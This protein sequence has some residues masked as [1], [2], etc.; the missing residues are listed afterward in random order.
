MSNLQARLAAF[1]PQRL[2]GIRRGIEKESLR[3]TPD[4]S[5]ALTPHPQALGAA[6]THPH[7][8]TDYSEAQLELITG[9]HAS[10]GDL[11]GRAAADPPVHLPRAGRRDAVGVEHAV[12][13]ARRREHPDRPLR[14]LQRRPRQERVPHGAGP[15]LRAAHADHLR[16]PL[17]LVAAGCVQRAVFRPDPQLPPPRVPAALPVRRVARRVQQL[18]RR[19][20]ARAATAGRR[21]HVH[22]ARHVAAHGAPGLPERRAGEPGRELQRAG[23]LHP[24]AAGGAHAAVSGVRGRGH[25]EPGRRIQPAGHQPAA[26]RERVLR[27]H[28][29]QAG[30]PSR[31]SARCTRCASAA[32][33]TSRCGCWT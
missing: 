24:V 17:Q 19:P 14:L 30:D 7:I 27:H 3:A 18:R 13:P 22:A 29:A 2:K 32:W 1:S 20:P 6:L 5:L 4:G 9:V 12:Q 15:P 31:A 26:D 21:H 11:P 33:S 8:T 25:R 16:H 10:A 28:P 23:R